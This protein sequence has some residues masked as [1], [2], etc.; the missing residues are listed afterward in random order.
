MK[1]WLWAMP[2]CLLLC[3]CG[4][5]ETPEPEFH[6]DIDDTQYFETV[7]DFLASEFCKEMQEDGFVTYLPAYDAEKYTLSMV[8]AV[9]KAYTFVLKEDE[10][11][12]ATTIQI[13]YDSYEKTVDELAGNKLDRSGDS[14]AAVEKDGRS[15]ELYVS[16]TP[17]VSHNEYNIM[18]IPFEK[19]K[20]YIGAKADSP[21]GAIDAFQE[22]DLLPSDEW[23]KLYGTE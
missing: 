16:K 19:Y 6:V 8:N 10:K 22:F 15:Y 18:C 7:P 9:R 5:K 13:R 12:G 2:L 3:G 21:Q 11:S 20:L 23:L 1:K 14:Y 4:A 17:Y